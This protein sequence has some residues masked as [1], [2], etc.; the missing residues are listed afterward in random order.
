MHVPLSAKKD[1]GQAGSS[2]TRALLRCHRRRG[3]PRRNFICLLAHVT[4]APCDMRRLEFLRLLSPRSRKGRQK[5][6]HW[7]T[8]GPAFRFHDPAL[9]F[10]KV[11]VAPGFEC[12]RL[13]RC[14]RR[15]WE[16]GPEHWA[17]GHWKLE[18]SR[19]RVPGAG[20]RVRAP[21]AK[22]RPFASPHPHHPHL[23]KLAAR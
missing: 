13:S 9:M 23:A 12:G 3:R 10:F 15:F 1:R 20:V 18:A 17:H 11:A 14:G 5:A 4:R 22:S 16:N 21:G 19:L 6:T 2:G 8:P 7:H